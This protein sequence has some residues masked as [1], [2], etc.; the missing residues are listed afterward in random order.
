M[1]IIGRQ[2]SLEELNRAAVRIARQVADDVPENTEKNLVAGN[3]SNSNIWNP[4]DPVSQKEV[5]SMFAEMV[6]WGVEEG[7]DFFIGET[8]YYAEEAFCALE[9]IKSAGLTA[10]LTIAPMGENIM[11]DNWSVV[12]SC[13]ELEQRGADVV[14]LNCFRGPSTMMPYLKKIRETLIKCALS[15]RR[16]AGSI[17]HQFRATHLL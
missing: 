17:S 2:D 11:R 7:V 16:P 6:G 10:V 12:D 3:I 14:G 15:C 4:A 8:F 13:K 1:K 5:R 9:T